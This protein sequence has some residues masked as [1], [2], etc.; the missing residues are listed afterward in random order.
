MGRSAHTTPPKTFED[1]LSEL[2]T[3][4]TSMEAGQLPL[5]QSL[6]AYKRGTELL[7]FCQKSLQDAQQQVRVLTEDNTLQDF[8]GG[9]DLG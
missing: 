1:A 4:V 6:V 7:Q 8:N 5:E 3:I 2:E 9:N